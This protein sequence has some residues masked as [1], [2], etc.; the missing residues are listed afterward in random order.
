MFFGLDNCG[1]DKGRELVLRIGKV[2]QRLASVGMYLRVLY[3]FRR[4]DTRLWYETGRGYPYLNANK[5][6]GGIMYYSN[7][8]EYS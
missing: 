1:L 4:R 3:K 2:R 6:A 5:S 8:I 7:P